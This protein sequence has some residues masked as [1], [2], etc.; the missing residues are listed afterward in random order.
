MPLVRAIEARIART[1]GFNVSFVSEQGVNIRGDRQISARYPSIN[2][3]RLI[4]RQSRSGSG[5]DSVPRSQASMS[6]YSMRGERS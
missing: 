1:E 6:R 2:G 3:A 4:R 5:H